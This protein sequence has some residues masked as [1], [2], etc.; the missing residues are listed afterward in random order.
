MKRMYYA[1]GNSG[2]FQE[3]SH[4]FKTYMPEIEILMCDRDFPEIQTLDQRTIAVDKARQAWEFLQQPVLADD[5]GIYFEKYNNFPGVYT[6]FVYEGIGMP[7]LLKL[8]DPGDRATFKLT[9]AYY[10][11]KHQCEVFE[12]IVAGHIAHQTIF[13]SH[14]K[15][16]YD[17]LF[18]PDNSG[19]RTFAQLRTTGEDVQFNYRVHALKKFLV[20]YQNE[21]RADV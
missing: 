12:G 6:K 7:G 10:H 16:P 1:T 18:V 15:L 21:M 9:L 17:A 13:P 20:W 5:A 8:V 14:P 19:N 4:F 2:K 11:G 3:V